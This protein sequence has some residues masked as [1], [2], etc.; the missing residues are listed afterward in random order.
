[1]ALDLSE[2]VLATDLDDLNE[3]FLTMIRAAFAKAT[4]GN[5]FRILNAEDGRET[6]FSAEDEMID[7]YSHEV[8]LEHVI[9]NKT[10]KPVKRKHSRANLDDISCPSAMDTD[11]ELAQKSVLA[12]TVGEE[13]VVKSMQQPERSAAQW[14][15]D[16]VEEV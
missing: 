14:L 4:W 13:V 8:I 16:D 7:K 2:E 11:G 15:D 9:L 12:K 10:K 5:W 1:M 6:F 3:H